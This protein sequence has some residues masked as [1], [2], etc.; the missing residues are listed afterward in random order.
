MK[1]SRFEYYAPGSVGDAISLIAEHGEDARFLAG[2][3]SLV[4][5]MN[6][7]VAAPPALIDLNGIPELSDVRIETGGALHVGAMTRTRR[8]ET[9]RE[10]AAANPLLAA[11]AAHVAHT[12]IRNRGTIGGSIAHA[13]PAAEMPGIALIC[14]AEI[15]LRS[16]AGERVVKASRFFDGVFTT[17]VNDG[18]LIEKIY[19]PPWPRQRRWAFQEIA[20]REGD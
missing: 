9:D 13:D 7:R 11:A 17:A 18:E 10:I 1:P 8:L 5:M 16:P 12:Q 6:F 19:F 2:G 20:R 4:P 15:H 3:Q 14:D